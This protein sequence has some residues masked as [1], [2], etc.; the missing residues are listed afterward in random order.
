MSCLE[1]LAVVVT[2]IPIITFLC[3]A[4]L[5]PYL[6]GQHYPFEQWTEGESLAFII[7]FPTTWIVSFIACCLWSQVGTTTSTPSATVDQL[8]EL[9]EIIYPESNYDF[10]RLKQEVQKLKSLRSEELNLELKKKKVN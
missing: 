1:D 7:L 9:N 4:F 3:L 6:V 5:F 8:I 10:P 2:F